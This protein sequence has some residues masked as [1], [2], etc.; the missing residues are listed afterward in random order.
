MKLAR[1]PLTALLLASVAMVH[2]ADYHVDSVAGDDA[3]DGRSPTTAWRSLPKVNAATFQ[4]GDRLLLKSGSA[5]TGQLHPNG[6]GSATDRIT[7]DRYGEGSKPVIHGGGIAGGAVVLENQQCWSIRNLE[8]TNQ[9]SP[10]AKKM[11]ILIRN[12]SVGT[13][14][15]I[16]VKDCH[17]HDVV[18]DLTDYR[19]GKE[20]GGI[21]FYINVA[22]LAVPSRWNDIL[23]ENNAIHDV[24][25][26]GIL[27]QSQWINKPND[28]N[29]NWK[30]HGA[31]TT[32][33]SIR[34]AGNTVERIGG[35]GIILWC[36]K[37]A[38]V[39]RNFVRQAN[40]NSLKQGHAAIWPYFCEDVVFQ[41]NEVCETKTKFDGMA[42]DFD[43]SN[44]RCVYQYNYSHD[45]EGGFLNMCC[46]GK[47]DDNIARYNV[48][49]ND[50]CL[51][52]SRVFLVHGHGNH[53][54]QVYNNT[55]YARNGNPA[56]FEQ[57][58]D[59]SGSSISF[60]NNIFVNAGT[61]T[62]VAPKG[63][64]F[65]RNLYFGAGHI[66]G[67]AKK[68]L[69]DP[70]LSAPCSGLMGIKSAAGYQLTEG[71]PALD[72]G[73]QIAAN[74]GEDYWGNAVSIDSAPHLGAYNGRPISEK[75]KPLAPPPLKK[76]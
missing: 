9:G 12:N 16:E 2:A 10:A 68:I 4:P 8:V 44:Q 61:G 42:F 7:L 50:G 5:W 26:N 55:I 1:L 22:N 57:G 17:I 48:S 75:H 14:S 35:D 47:A 60:K 37:G 38:M 30:G 20:S 36:V 63:C 11:G 33:T 39:E 28:P 49:Q 41:H 13:L 76:D 21:V 15:G 43:N 24:A 64:Q 58:A 25:R 3:N 65:E 73:L 29:S 70:R 72:A 59:S 67:D 18:G 27:M 69:A 66:A 45:N 51:A 54:Y 46:D 19:D 34:V 6:S 52:G 32:S 23:I 40:N 53:S 71:S 31:Y 62:F 74:G 56:M